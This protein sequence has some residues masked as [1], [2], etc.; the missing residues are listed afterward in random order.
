MWYLPWAIR[1]NHPNLIFKGGLQRHTF[2]LITLLMWC[3]YF[4]SGHLCALCN[5]NN[6]IG[7]YFRIS[8]LDSHFIE[9][10]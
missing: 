10:Y 8:R 5:S 2:L 7:A 6:F 4:V 9:K 3:I 1:A